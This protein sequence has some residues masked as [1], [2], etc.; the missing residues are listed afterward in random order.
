[1]P[2]IRVQP[3]ELKKLGISIREFEENVFMIGADLK[4]IADD[5]IQVEL[6]PDRPDMYT[7]EGIARALKLYLGHM[8]PKK[9]KVEN[10]LEKIT[11]EQ[12]V[13]D[14]RPF[15]VAAVI[16][17]VKMDKTMIKS[18]MD[19]QEKLHL[20]VGRKRK[21]IAIGLHDYDKVKGPFT[22]TTRP[23]DFSFVPLGFNAPMTLKE[24]LKTHPKGIDYAHLLSNTKKYPVIIDSLGEV[25]SFP[26]IINGKLTEINP[27]TKNIF[28]DI[29]GIDMTSLLSVLN[30]VACSFA[31]RGASIETVVI[32]YNSNVMT[33]PDLNYREIT[34]DRNY[35]L[36][37]LGV[38]LSD[39]EISN[40]L[41]KM[42]YFTTVQG[43]KI[44]VTVPPYRMDIL[45]PVDI[46]EDIA[47]GYGYDSIPKKEITKYVHGKGFKWEEKPR[48]S[49][50]GLGFLEIKSLTLSSFAQQYLLMHIPPIEKVVVE[51]PVSE[52]T[53]TLRTWLI[54]GLMEI[55][56][57]NRHR[58]LPQR[59][60]EIGYIYTSE[61]ERHAAFLYE[62]SKVGFTDAK[63]II[64][65]VL[66][67]LGVGDYHIEEKEM[68][69]YI[70]GRCASIM[71][72]GKEYGHF[73]EIH[74]SVL[75][76]FELG[77]PV[78]GGEIN[79]EKIEKN[80]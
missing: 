62:D 47:K 22:Y 38:S 61:L 25:L 43:S 63:S 5:E 37:T 54:P 33:T 53:E 15:I 12:S 16:R 64:E 34:L 1:M 8:P 41:Q 66:G 50:L 58:D 60:F 14:I 46:V 6:F 19:F 3:Q 40:S 70:P 48:L 21:K 23:A 36:K 24:I 78:V 51:N 49:F 4:E 59:I 13:S 80:L 65:R 76:N 35:A 28:I 7:V 29:T 44:K 32:S 18:M 79:L 39:K 31:D 10:G 57:K 45:H 17:N 9:Y 67:D 71:H 30:I 2:V 72:N 52:M 11:V 55:L 73:G 77:Y 27:Q 26:P 75:E 68:G 20:T 42:G 56:R 74:P 69:T